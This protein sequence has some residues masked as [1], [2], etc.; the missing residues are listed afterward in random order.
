[1][2]FKWDIFYHRFLYNFDSHGL[3]LAGMHHIIL[4]DQTHVMTWVC[5]STTAEQSNCELLTEIAEQRLEKWK[6]LNVEQDYEIDPVWCFTGI[7]FIP[8]FY[9]ILTVTSF[10]K[11]FR[12]CPTRKIREH[13]DI[14]LSW[15]SSMWRFPCLIFSYAN[16]LLCILVI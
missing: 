11:S 6:T 12:S 16:Y 9:I 3:I 2:V 8:G 1:M 14:K 4:L 13:L 7:F 5:R 10:L 15:S